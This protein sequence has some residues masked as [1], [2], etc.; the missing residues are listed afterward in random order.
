V[1][2][3]AQPA[4]PARA[5]SLET[6]WPWIAVGLLTLAGFAL[7]YAGLREGLFGDELYLYEIVKQPDLGDVLRR[8]HDTESTPPFHFVLAWA[9]T[10]LGDPTVTVRLPSLV[11]GTALIPFTYLLGSRTIGR[12]PALLGAAFLAL[13]PFAIW[14]ADEA[15]AYATMAFLAVASALALLNALDTRRRRWWALYALC[16]CL[17]LYTHYMGVFV[18]VAAGA[19]G[20]WAHRD[21]WRE[22]AWANGAVVVAYLPWLPSFAV[23]SEDTSA[24]RISSFKDFTPKGVVRELTISVDGHP[25]LPLSGVPGRPALVLL[26]LGAAA[27]V[28]G[29]VVLWRRIRA[30]EPD[31]RSRLVLV[32]LL[33]VATPAGVAAYSILGKN[34]YIPRNLSASLPF[35][36]L[37]LAAGAAALRRPLWLVP[38]AL[39][40]AGL[41]VGTV[42]TLDPDRGRPPYRAAAHFVDDRDRGDGIVLEYPLFPAFAGTD[43]AIGHHLEVHFSE[44]HPLVQARSPQ[45]AAWDRVPRYHRLFVV[46]PWDAVHR[47]AGSPLPRRFASRFRLVDMGV[48]RGLVPVA[49]FEYDRR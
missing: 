36:C 25:F 40:L 11:L 30:G 21:R 39:L 13:S 42:R 18:V 41:G 22:L 5:G 20:F 4:R 7:R 49:V 10:K 3:T 17:I 24:N 15:R 32:W 8:V 45:D 44:P 37:A 31:A 43:E 16:A 46:T 34:T 2:A 23:Q 12:I 6:A 29:S 33:A 27:A 38:A 19:W 47:D 14:Y 26:S 48:W 35:I 9:A 1:T 28:A